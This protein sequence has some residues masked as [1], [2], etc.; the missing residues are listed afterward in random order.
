MDYKSQALHLDFNIQGA[1]VMKRK[2]CE[3]ERSDSGPSVKFSRIAD[4]IKNNFP[5]KISSIT[6]KIVR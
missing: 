4:D 1:G 6:S 5:D 2:Y 3:V